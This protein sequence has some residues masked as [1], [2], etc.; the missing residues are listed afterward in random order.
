MSGTQRLRDPIHGLIVFDSDNDKI[1]WKLIETPEMQ[2]LRRIKQLGFSEFTFP[3]ATH[4]RFSHSI[5]VCNNARKLM[6][7][8]KD[9]E[10]RKFDPKR[11]E[12]VLY[13][14]L[15]HDIGHGPFSHA[16]ENSREAI[17]KARGK[18]AIDNHEIYSARIIRNVDGSIFPIL[19]DRRPGL[20]NEVAAIIEAD[21][22]VDIYHAVI[23]SSF[24]ADRLDF[25]VRDRYMTGTGAG[26]IDDDWLIDN[27]TEKQIA[28]AQDD[29]DEPQM[30]PTFVFKLKGRQAAEDFLLARYRLYTEVYLHKTTRGLETML[31]R[32]L[33]FVGDR[34]IPAED[35]ALDGHSSLVRFLRERE[36][37][38][39]Y[40]DLDDYE[41]WSAVKRMRA[42]KK[43]NV[44]ELAQRLLNR[45]HYFVLDLFREFGDDSARLAN[46]RI[47][48]E[49]QFENEISDTVFRDAPS[50]NLYSANEGEAE[51][52]HKVVRIMDGDGKP[53]EIKDFENTIIS[54]K[55][56]EKRR[57][58]RYYF[59]TRE[60][61]GEA[62]KAARGN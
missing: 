29:D 25:L 55:L 3:G 36:S 6:R 14:A 16:F 12:A 26:A 41:I 1:A 11:E 2:R 37:V 20:S 31:S 45:E 10:G 53:V 49:K 62:L 38:A 48:V 50:V 27:L 39:D 9:S 32:L 13:A 24:D 18:D 58:I 34:D 43:A 22:P 23:S 19:E 56:T 40:L 54:S 47:A 51:K 8:V 28:V 61:R 17:A 21:D 57:L 44:G 33:R 30:V 4:N 35:L 15:L 59:P 42:S 46:A 60:L 5:G 7:V 52:M